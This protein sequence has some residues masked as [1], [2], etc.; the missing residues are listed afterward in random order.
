LGDRATERPWRERPPRLETRRA[1][2]ETT[3][4]P[5]HLYRNLDGSPGVAIG[6]VVGEIVRCGTV[7]VE[8]RTQRPRLGECLD[9]VRESVG[10]P[11]ALERPR[12]EEVPQVW[13]DR[14]SHE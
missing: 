1:G 8:P 4:A 13:L 5:E 9:V 11:C 7:V 12:V 10:D 14:G 6:A 3:V 2:G